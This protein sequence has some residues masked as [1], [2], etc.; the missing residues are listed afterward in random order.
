VY[1]YTKY[2]QL[3]DVLILS[4]YIIMRLKTLFF[5]FFK[6]VFLNIKTYKIIVLYYYFPPYIIL[7]NNFYIY[8][9]DIWFKNIILYIFKCI[10][11]L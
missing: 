10:T 3:T 4:V 6:E 11:F 5:L 8:E 1:T 9:E 2:N 7:R